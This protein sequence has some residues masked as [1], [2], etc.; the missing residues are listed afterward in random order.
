[1]DVLT[2]PEFVADYARLAEVS[3]NPERH[4]APHARAHCD[5]VAERVA[6]LARRA[7]CDDATRERLVTLARVHD[8]GKLGGDARPAASVERLHRY[9]VEDPELLALVSAHDLNLPWWKSS[10]RGE[11]PSDRAWRK[12][13]RRVDVRTLALFMI[14]DRVDAP[15]GWRSNEPLMW[16]L[17]EA[18]RRGLLDLDLEAIDPASPEVSVERCAGALLVR[19]HEGEPQV[20]MIRVRPEVWELPK[21]HIEA[22]E[23]ASEAATRELREETGLLGSVRVLTTLGHQR[24][25]FLRGLGRVHKDVEYFLCAPVDDPPLLGPRPSGTREC[26]WISGTELASLPVVSAALGSLVERGLAL[27]GELRP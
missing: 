1:M 8:I 21:G 3:L 24:H 20:L 5:Q 23:E 18:A 26:R 7:G 2:H 19:E 12:L 27:A 16:F 22:G 17:G 11:A 15:G 14:A 10:K 4:R 13:A 6:E 25:S 9:G